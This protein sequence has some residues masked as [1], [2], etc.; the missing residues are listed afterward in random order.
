M[1]GRTVATKQHYGMAG[2][3]WQKSPPTTTHTIVNP[4]F[5][6]P[7][8]KSPARNQGRETLSSGRSATLASLYF[9]M[10]TPAA[11]PTSYSMSFKTSPR[12]ALFTRPIAKILFL[13]NIW[14]KA[15]CNMSPFG[16]LCHRFLWT[17]ATLLCL[18]SPLRSSGKCPSFSI[19]PFTDLFRE[20]PF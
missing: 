19:F 14:V 15:T 10:P 1:Q 11:F 12:K 18:S 13:E 8:P 3:R 7:E 17:M 9:P 6:N 20:Q 2:R 16:N 5:R 4:S